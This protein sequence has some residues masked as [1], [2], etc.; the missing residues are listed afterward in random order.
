MALW[1]WLVHRAD[2]AGI[3]ALEKGRHL[4]PSGHFLR[5][6]RQLDQEKCKRQERER[7]YDVDDTPSTSTLWLNQAH[8]DGKFRFRP[9]IGKSDDNTR[10]FISTGTVWDGL[11]AEAYP[12]GPETLSDAPS[13][14]A[15]GP[16][17]TI[18]TLSR[19]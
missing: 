17:S 1:S 12:H 16:D 14:T 15:K 7:L 10:P 3:E 13:P 11:P 9:S 4:V 8:E 5:I 6:M 19:Q 2:K 18:E